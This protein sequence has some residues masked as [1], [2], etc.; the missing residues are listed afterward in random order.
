M[1]TLMLNIFMFVVLII[2]GCASEIK[3]NTFKRYEE[4]TKGSEM[5]RSS[6]NLIDTDK[7]EFART[8]ESGMLSNLTSSFIL[9][10]SEKNPE[11]QFVDIFIKGKTNEAKIYALLGLFSLN[12]EKYYTYM[13]QLNGDGIVL[14]QEGC[15]IFEVRVSDILVK[16]EDGSL[17]QKVMSY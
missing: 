17:L 5:K 8:D 15:L 10:L 9:V 12:R 2:S 7:I 6:Q 1:K 16:I 14:V 13:E 11:K 4:D 3:K